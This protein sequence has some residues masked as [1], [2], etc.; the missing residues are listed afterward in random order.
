MRSTAR[1]STSTFV[2]VSGRW[3]LTG[4]KATILLWNIRPYMRLQV[5]AATSAIALGMSTQYKPA[6]LK[7][8]AELGWDVPEF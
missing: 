5:P 8:M 6:T 4:G 2:S 3:Q 7:K 1:R